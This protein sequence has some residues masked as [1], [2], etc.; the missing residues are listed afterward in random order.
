A[1]TWDVVGKTDEVLGKY[2]ELREELD[3]R[4]MIERLEERVAKMHFTPRESALMTLPIIPVK[5]SF[6][7]TSVSHKKIIPALSVGGSLGF[8]VPRVS[9]L[10]SQ[11]TGF[12]FGKGGRRLIYR[13]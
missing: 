5:S 9:K 12:L 13:A 11:E 7:G 1:G 8:S 10:I 6:L 2:R 4:G 3:S